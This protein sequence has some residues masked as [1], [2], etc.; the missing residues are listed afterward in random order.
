ME[1]LTQNWIWILLAVGVFFM[2]RRGGMGCGFGGHRSHHGGHG[3][4]QGQDV[5]RAES[6][7]IDP[8]SGQAVA[9]ASALTS[10]YRGRT[11]YFASRENRDRFEA[12]PER[13]A[14]AEPPH[15]H[16]RHRHG[17]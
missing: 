16:R 12:Q 11:Y 13:Y 5:A 2:M 3:D 15:E 9:A 10:V 1:W 6:S 14:R 4:E 8:V 17:C 7:T